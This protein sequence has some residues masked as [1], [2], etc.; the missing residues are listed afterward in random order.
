MKKM[1]FIIMLTLLIGFTKF[2]FA[3]E[4]QTQEK[5]TNLKLAQIFMQKINLT[6]PAS[7][8]NLS[9][10]DYYSALANALSSRG[11]NYFLNTK[12]DDFVICSGLI[13]A[14]YG[15]TGAKEQLNEEAKLNYLIASH[16]MES[17]PLKR[18]DTVSE[19]FV[20]DVLNNPKF[21]ALIAETYTPPGGERRGGDNPGSNAPGIAHEN[22]RTT[23]HP[24]STI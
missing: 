16:Y 3:A 15:L 14:L 7:S 18:D 4:N 8:N 19:Q 24:A 6:L 12:P 17:C 11:I 21:S 20:I 10:A 5:I 1:A 23:Q 22:I 2:S 9:P 13:N